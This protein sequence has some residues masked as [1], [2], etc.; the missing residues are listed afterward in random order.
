MELH[1]LR[2]ETCL[3]KRTRMCHVVATTIVGFHNLEYQEG[4]AWDITALVGCASHSN[5]KSVIKHGDCPDCPILTGEDA[6]KFNEYI[7]D[8]NPQCTPEGIE[9]IKEANRLA[10]EASPGY[11]LDKLKKWVEDNGFSHYD[12]DHPYVNDCFVVNADELLVK[13]E[14][15]RKKLLF[16]V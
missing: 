5:F 15:F 7:N 1:P 16:F 6:V 2:C 9:L 14:E 3:K 12:P 8:P 11:Q 4:F 13:I 10:K